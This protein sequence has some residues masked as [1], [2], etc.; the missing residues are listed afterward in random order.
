MA[1]TVEL[2]THAVVHPADIQDCDGGPL[3]EATLFGYIR[4]FWNYMPMVA[5]MA[6]L[7][8]EIVKCSDQAKGS[9]VPL[10]R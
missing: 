9:V 2:L 8:V 3:F 4:S 10:K 6:Q 1:A 5:I 7:N